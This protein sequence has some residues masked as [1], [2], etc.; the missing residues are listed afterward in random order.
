MFTSIIRSIYTTNLNIKPHESVLI[1]TDTIQPGESLSESD[2]C[3]RLHLQDVALLTAEVG[4][5]FAKKVHY[6]Q[7]PAMHSHGVEPPVEVWQAAFGKKA[8]NALEKARVLEPI[9]LKKTTGDILLKAKSILEKHVGAAVDAIIALANYST[10]HTRFRE[11]LT[12]VSGA[13]Y[14][15]MPLFDVSMFDGPMSVDW[16]ALDRRT[17]AIA[18]MVN[19]AEMVEI[20]T[21]DGSHLKLSKKGRTALPDTGMLK[22]P[23]AFSNLPAGEVFFAPVEGIAEGQLVLRWGPTRELG[24][25]ITLVVS[26]GMVHSV[27]G[28]DPYADML[29]ATLAERDENRNIAELG[30]GTNDRAKRPD[31]ILEAEKILGTVHVA[32]G[33]NSSFG[34]VVKTPYH[35]DFVF[36]KPTVILLDPDGARSVLMTNGVLSRKT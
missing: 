34:G 15:S 20:T 22:K 31:N 27:I 9:L 16:K 8:I 2:R 35:Q 23:G 12:S 21:P 7:Y 6:V 17:R 32:L 14:A 3:R 29:R 24:C 5:A 4:R 1:F 36:F 30:I 28:N 18:K 13:R 11:L 26:E 19:N 33:D 10:S 25:P